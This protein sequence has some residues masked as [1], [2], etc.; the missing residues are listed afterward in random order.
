MQPIHDID[1]V[2]FRNQAFIGAPKRHSERHHERNAA[3]FGNPK[4]LEVLLDRLFDRHVLVLFR[5]GRADGD[6]TEHLVHFG[7][8]SAAR[9]MR[10]RNQRA[11]DRTWLAFYPLENLLGIARMGNDFWMREARYFDDGQAQLRKQIDHSHLGVGIDPARKALQTIAR[12]DF[13]DHHR[14]GK[15][16][17]HSS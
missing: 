7:H 16:Q 2:R 8:R 10:I 13:G 15:R 6:Q 1:D 4:R 12:A 9:A 5:I 3:C 14:A 11:I 17:G